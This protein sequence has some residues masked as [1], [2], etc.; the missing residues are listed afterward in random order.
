MV[1]EWDYR[2]NS[3]GFDSLSVL[4]NYFHFFALVTR[5]NATLFSIQF[6]LWHMLETKMYG[7][8]LMLWLQVPNIY[9]SIRFPLPTLLCEWS[10]NWKKN[11]INNTN[12][13]KRKITESIRHPKTLTGLINSEF[14]VERVQTL[15][16]YFLR[17]LV[18]L[19]GVVWN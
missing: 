13:S 2:H 1:I 4:I 9:H 5:Q 6:V 10:Y 12:R 15:F 11:Q 17:D 16:I 18:F 7:G 8:Y 19:F 14:I 3:C